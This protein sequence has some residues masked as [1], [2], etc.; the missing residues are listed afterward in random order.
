MAVR[1]DRQ[2]KDGDS[3]A[4]VFRLDGTAIGIL[5][6]SWKKSLLFFTLNAKL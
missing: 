5:T 6:L 2:P 3:G 4:P 1:F